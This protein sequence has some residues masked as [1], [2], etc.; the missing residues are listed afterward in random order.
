[1]DGFVRCG[2]LSVTVAV[3]RIDCIQTVR[4]PEVMASPYLAASG[5]QAVGIEGEPL[6]L[7]I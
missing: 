5:S 2:C 7:C 3:W 4:V 6:W 1:V